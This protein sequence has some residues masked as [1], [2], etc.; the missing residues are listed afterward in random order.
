MC[1]ADNFCVTCSAGYF[2]SSGSCQTCATSCTCGGWVLPKVNGV[3]STLCGDGIIIGNEK[4]DDG[5]TNDHDGCSSACTIEPCNLNCSCDGWVHPWVNGSCSTLC[6]DS[7]LRGQEKCDDG[8]TNDHD[9]CSSTCTIEPCDLN[10]SCDGW[11]QP[12]VNGSC[13]SLCG[14][15]M[16]RG[17]E[18]CDDGN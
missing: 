9:G 3:C 7:L 15:N 11:V 14:D 17:V 10:C 12:W 8:N 5:N 13:S 18:L 16:T 2:V 1:N 4:C 6:G